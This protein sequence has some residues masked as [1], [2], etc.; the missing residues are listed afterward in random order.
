MIDASGVNHLDATADH[1]LRKLM[2]RL[3]EQHI[4]LLFVNVDGDVRAVM[5]A[6]GLA[7]LI[8]RDH[9]FPT[10]ADALSYLVKRSPLR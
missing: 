7:D 3:N 2:V 5:E 10:D 6:S 9:F 4:V 8:G 1:E